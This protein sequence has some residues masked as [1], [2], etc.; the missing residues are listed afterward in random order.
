MRPK[1]SNSATALVGRALCGDSG[2]S[3]IAVPVNSYAARAGSVWCFCEAEDFLWLTC[4]IQKQA[5]ELLR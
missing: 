4:F 2:R 3:W 5:V 1:D